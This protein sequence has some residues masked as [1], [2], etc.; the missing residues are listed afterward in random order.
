M[1]IQIMALIA[2]ALLLVSCSPA[3]IQ[4]Q[5]DAALSRNFEEYT[6]ELK[7]VDG[8]LEVISDPQGD[9]VTGK[10]KGWVGF[11][12]GTHGIIRFVLLGEEGKT[13]CTDDPGTS[14]EWVMTQVALSQSGN[15]TTQKGRDFGD[16]PPNWMAKEFPTISVNGYLVN[17][18]TSTA[19][20]S[21]VLINVN[22]NS[23][24]MMAFYEIEVSRCDDPGVK[25]KTDPGIGNAGRK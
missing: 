2:V 18:P 20:T 11:A 9:D 25:L 24:R 12:R 1:K 22:G 19:K 23:G 13:G 5:N 6:V 15:R 14:A 17:E 8:K 7:V 10:N 21:A 4:I 16:R 3:P